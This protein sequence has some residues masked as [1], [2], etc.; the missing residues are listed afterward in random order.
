MKWLI[1]NVILV[2]PWNLALLNTSSSLISSQMPQ[3]FLFQHS[4][5]DIL[6]AEI[7]IVTPFNY[8]SCFQ[9][10]LQLHW[11][12]PCLQVCCLWQG[13]ELPCVCCSRPRRKEGRI[14]SIPV[15]TAD[16]MLILKP[17]GRLTTNSKAGLPT[18]LLTIMVAPR[19]WQPWLQ[20]SF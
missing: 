17:Q 18:V 7:A 20:P 19:R 8:C 2:G 16:E 15:A 14:M 6:M 11:C 10:W 9:K 13:M 3:H 4:H 5:V 12:W 1:L